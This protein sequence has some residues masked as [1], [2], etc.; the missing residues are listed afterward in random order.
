M[1][2]RKNLDVEKT[3]LEREILELQ[4]RANREITKR[5]QLEA[6]Y[7]REWEELVKVSSCYQKISRI[8]HKLFV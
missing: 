8:D 2:K 7:A 4:R 5:E 1:K 3:K 6:R